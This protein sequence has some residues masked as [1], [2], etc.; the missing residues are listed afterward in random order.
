[1]DNLLIE[2]NNFLKHNGFDYVFCGGHAIDIYLG[3]STRKHG[4]IDLSA[5]WKDRNKIIDFMKS[6]NWII[7]E[8]MGSGK[9]HLITDK[10][11][12]MMN[13]HNIFCVKNECKF[14]HTE[15]IGNDIYQCKID[16]VEQTELD[17][18]EFL[19]NEHTE[20]EFIYSRN[21]T[22]SYELNKAIL[23]KGDMEYFAPELVLLYKSTDLS[24]EEN[25]QD[26]D[27]VIPYL[28]IENITWLKNVL[29]IANPDG[30][31]WISRLEKG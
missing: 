12:Q 5:Y 13:K 8:A 15:Y 11:N 27:T 6:E 29:I 31:E 3:Y 23:H 14:F 22:I 21:N 28:P 24:R 18:I 10:N 9:I 4:D 19:F 17:Y 2:C 1:M 26:F 16:H 7:Y 30:H 20:K 25:R